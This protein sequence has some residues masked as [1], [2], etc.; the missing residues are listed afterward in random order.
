[1]CRRILLR[2]WRP[3]PRRRRSSRSSRTACSA[4]TSTT[5]TA[6][7][8]PTRVGG[9]SRRRSRCSQRG[10][11]ASRLSIYEDQ[12][13]QR[14]G[15]PEGTLFD[16]TASTPPQFGHCG[17]RNC[18]LG[19]CRTERPARALPQRRFAPEFGEEGDWGVKHLEWGTAFFTP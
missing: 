18:R 2:P 8:R 4:T 7:R 1:M 16:E 5:S 6:L 14:A 12:E 11:S 19:L 9:A 17:H 3:T 15:A 10:A 13:E